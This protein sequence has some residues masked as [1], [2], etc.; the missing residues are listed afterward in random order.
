MRGVLYPE[1]DKDWIILKMN[2]FGV[3]KEQLAAMV[4]VSVQIVRAWTTGRK[5]PCEKNRGRLVKIFAPKVA[6]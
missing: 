4:P 2:E 1:V 3:S 6:S 5:T